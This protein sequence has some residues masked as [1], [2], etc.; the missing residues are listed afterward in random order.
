MN[1]TESSASTWVA[2]VGIVCGGVLPY[3]PQYV[4]MVRSGDTSGFSSWVCLILLIANTTRVCFYVRQKFALAL[5]LQ[6]VVMMLAQTIMLELVVRKSRRPTAAAAPIRLYH[7]DRHS[8]WKWSYFRDYVA[9]LGVLFAGA[10]LLYVSLFPSSPSYTQLVGVIA[11]GTEACLGLPQV[12]KNHR[13]GSTDG[14]SIAMVLGWAFGDV[15]KTVYS[16][17]VA[18]PPQF[19]LCGATQTLVDACLLLQIAY[20]KRQAKL[21]HTDAK[22]MYAV[23]KDADGDATKADAPASTGRRSS[24]SVVVPL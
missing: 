18:S 23:I 5:L 14:V 20:F 11:L 3:V 21:R 12:L 16:V 8:F 19:V 22:V 1:G 10:W 17:A 24:A 13:R 6:S 4:Y 7:W 15:F 2:D 9:A